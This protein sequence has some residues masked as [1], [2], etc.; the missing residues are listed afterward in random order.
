MVFQLLL[1]PINL[2][3]RF[4]VLNRGLP[5]PESEQICASKPGRKIVI[6]CTITLMAI[7]CSSVAFLR[8]SNF[9]ASPL[10][11]NF[12]AASRSCQSK[13]MGG[14]IVNVRK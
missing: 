8:S 4:G 11:K 7:L 13:M 3:K 14:N 1:D 2:L 6:V 12:F 5:T 10:S 9:G